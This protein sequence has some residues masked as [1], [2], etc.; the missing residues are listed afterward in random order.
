MENWIIL[1]STTGNSGETQITL[2]VA[3]NTNYSAR[4]TT[5]TV[6]TRSKNLTD[7]VVINQQARAAT[8]QMT[9]NP[10]ALSYTYEGGTIPFSITANE[11]WRVVSWPT[12]VG[13][14]GDG[15]SGGTGTY[16]WGVTALRN[17]SQSDL[18]STF[19]FYCGGNYFTVPVHQ[20]AYSE[21][22]TGSTEY[23]T[24][25][26]ISGG[27]I[28]WK[29]TGNTHTVEYQI[30]GGSWNSITS[31]TGGTPITVSAGD[32]VK[33][34]GDNSNY[35]NSS[36][37]G[38]TA[39]FKVK[40]NIMSLIDSDNY[41]SLDS[42]QSAY[43]FYYLFQNCTG[44]TDASKLILPATTLSN[45][46]YGGMFYNC[47]SLATAPALPSTTLSNNCY[48]YMFQGCS[49]LTTAPALPATTL[50]NQCYYG[51]FYNCTSLTTA[52][53][54]TSNHFSKLLL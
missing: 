50:A 11:D 34:R 54:F 24:F 18:D 16:N 48:F 7:T 30:N 10:S 4:T 28:Y 5:L 39:G 53:E 27:T 23:L 29:T 22:P 21:Q 40:N 14:S 9:F 31:S 32:I 8:G 20:D 19:T 35:N 46:C 2:Q 47:T 25:E 37:S 33:W 12:W 15:T 49:N 43:T 36:F 17:Y 3:E 6:R 13:I 45:N 1:N 52:P 26:I 42:L 51:M 38:T 44:L 41:A